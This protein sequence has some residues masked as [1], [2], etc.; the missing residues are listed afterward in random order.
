[1]SKNNM[2]GIFQD[3]QFGARVL[4][5]NPGFT[6]V[7]VLSLA[8]GIG[9]NTAIFQLL[10]AVRLK[11]LPVNN[12]AQ[13]VRVELK[14]SKGTRG[15]H[16]ANYSAVTNPIWEKIRDRQQGFE[17]LTAWGTQTFNMAQGGEVRPARGLWVSG[18]FFNVLGVHAQ[19]GRLFNASDDQRGC[20]SPGVVLSNGFWQKE[21]G[22]NPDAIG[23][24]ISL[25][26]QQFEIVGITEPSFYGL[27]VGKAFDVAVPI[28]ADGL[29]SAKNNRLDSGVNWWLM[30]TGRL[31]PG[32]TTEQA[33]AQLQT[34]SPA[35]FQETLPAN[36]PP[37]SVNDYLNFKLEV[38]EGSSGYSTLRENYERP[39]WLLLAIAGL[40]LLI[41]C[42]NLANLL[43]ARANTRER[44]MAIRQAVGASRFRIVRQLLVET[45]L[46]SVIGTVLGAFLAQG[47]SRFL[48]SFIG[49]ARDTVFLDLSPDFR[50]LGFAAAAATLTCILF[51]ITPALRATRVSPG[52][53]M[54]SSGRGL[55]AG[56]ERF[57]AR[58][59]LVVVQVALS[60]V[61]VASAL[62]FT[63]SLNNLLN[64]DAGFKQDG[65]LISRVSYRRLN[66]P[67]D[68]RLS[69][70][71]E[72][73]DHIKS[74]PGVDAVTE[75]DSVPL[76]GW[77]R[78]NVVWLNGS[79]SQAGVDASFNRVGTDYFKTL[80]IDLL[81]G[82]YFNS[83][84]AANSPKVAIVD[85]TFA[86]VL[87][88][89]NPVGRTVFVEATP[90]EP[91]TPYQIV[92]LVRGGR[93][94]DLKDDSIPSVYLPTLQDPQPMTSKQFLIRSSLPPGNITPALSRS[95]L[96]VNPGLD[97]S[98]QGFR[99]MVQESLLRERLMATLSGFFGLLA[100][101]LASIGLYGLLS[102]GV[103]SRTN[104]IGIR[105]ALGART[106]DVLTM[107]LREAFLLVLIGVAVGLPVVFLV[108]RF[109]SALLFGLSPTDPV[110]LI[111][112]AA[113][114][115]VVAFLAGY[116]PARK[117][118]KIDPLDAL[119]YE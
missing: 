103:A 21:F 15:N 33:T 10:N 99:S 98:F 75:M 60:L 108:T 35:I 22:G 54:K 29:I 106:R 64:L 107:I 25:A 23:R 113:L 14:D 52:A 24:K 49:T 28:C 58:R 51:G 105:L 94:T 17:G 40:V 71:T 11:T 43:L 73:L 77:G 1:M 45:L 101:L 92:G 82:R 88:D 114:L 31:K 3:L 119:R 9:A 62:L 90:S 12:A 57:S 115:L 61:L 26:D 44:E 74:V 110:S 41:T 5:K 81:G 53:A 20:A 38:L 2:G 95:L 102:Y 83:S 68:R 18:E 59:A 19:Q 89:P 39:L 86:R 111:V 37:V 97:I 78:G 30:V 118:T 7:A 91:E 42:A 47:L 70:T 46:L 85:E 116:L 36:Y 87:Q 16:S 34:I 50:V 65:L 32:W 67:A 104:E 72:L 93:V 100:L 109:A 6:T 80:Q 48:V 63:R 76:T 117:A 112:A 8:L 55:T 84:D 13:L 96:E 69:F 56:R 79:N 66:V 4:R 27:E